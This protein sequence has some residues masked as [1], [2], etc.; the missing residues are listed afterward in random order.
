MPAEDEVLLPKAAAILNDP[1]FNGIG[2]DRAIKDMSPPKLKEYM[3]GQYTFLHQHYEELKAQLDELTRKVKSDRNNLVQRIER[4]LLQMT[5]HMT[6]IRQMIDIV[7]SYGDRITAQEREMS[8]RETE[9]A[10]LVERQNR[11]AISLAK[12][13]KNSREIVE[14]LDDVRQKEE[15]HS[16]LEWRVMTVFA[17][18][19][20]IV[21]W[22]LTGDHFAQ[23]LNAIGQITS[24]TCST[25]VLPR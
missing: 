5:H 13:E 15:S 3:E 20:A 24:S 6:I 2:F 25:G 19:A 11:F 7:S 17:I 10:S 21:A 4:I 12:L 8:K 16:K 14:E 18:G 23:I 22:L 9:H 1:L